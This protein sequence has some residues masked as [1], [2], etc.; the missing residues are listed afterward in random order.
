MLLRHKKRVAQVGLF[1]LY[2]AALTPMFN[3]IRI[4]IAMPTESNSTI[5][6]YFSK[7]GPYNLFLAGLLTLI[8]I[9]FFL[10]DRSK[11]AWFIQFFGILWIGGNDTI[12]ALFF[13]L[14]SGVPFLPTMLPLLVTVCNFIG[15]GCIKNYVFSTEN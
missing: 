15:L 3:S 6:F 12:G 9:M 11:I 7:I 2:L 14:D 4:W 5:M 1:L 10:L 8:N 13:Y